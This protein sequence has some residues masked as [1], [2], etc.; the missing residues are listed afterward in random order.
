V[1]RELEKRLLL[2]LTTFILCSTTL[3]RAEENPQVNVRIYND[4][5]VASD[6]LSQAEQEATRIFANAGFE[7]IWLNC[8]C[9]D[10][11]PV[12]PVREQIEGAASLALHIMDQ[13]AANTSD[14]AFGMAFLGP[15]GTGRYGDVFWNRV[16]ELQQNSSVDGGVILG[17]VMAHEIGHLLLGSNA[18]AVGGIMVPHW[19]APE[20]HR[21]SMG[22]LL[23]LPEQAKR[24]RARMTSP[25][26][27]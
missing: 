12:R 5:E 21:I 25:G 27:L 19:R 18:H 17:G 22:T 8:P 13:V 16:R 15:G 10:G 4:A 24:M 9:D 1:H 2:A 7:I 11:A 6:T 3:T 26:G 20:L 23:F 14:A